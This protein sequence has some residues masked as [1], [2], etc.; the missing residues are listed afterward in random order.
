MSCFTIG[1]AIQDGIVDFVEWLYESD[2]GHTGYGSLDCCEADV[3]HLGVN[4]CTLGDG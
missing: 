2:H 1:L 3:N 4:V